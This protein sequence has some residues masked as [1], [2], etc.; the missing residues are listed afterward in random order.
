MY[1]LAL[2]LTVRAQQPGRLHLPLE[3]AGVNVSLAQAIRE[4]DARLREGHLKAAL[5]WSD[6][7]RARIRVT[8][9]SRGGWSFASTLLQALA[10]GSAL[11]CAGCHY[12]VESVDLTDS[13]WAAVSTWSDMLGHPACKRMRFAFATPLVTS[14]PAQSERLNAFP[15]PDPQVL[16]ASLLRHW[17][18]L[19]GPLL[20]FVGEHLALEA[21]CVVSEYRLETAERVLSGRVHLGFLGWIEYACNAREAGATASLNALARLAFFTDCGYLTECGMGVSSV[22]IAN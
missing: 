15:F 22:T 10:P 3:S 18:M 5:F 21:R 2:L 7:E 6:Q 9:F 16:F 20:P 1:F 11:Q 17:R 13:M 19:D 4:K 14:S 8:C 12:E